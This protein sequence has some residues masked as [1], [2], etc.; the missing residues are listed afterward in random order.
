M[1]HPR[2]PRCGSDHDIDPTHSRRKSYQIDSD[3]YPKN[4]SE[5]EV[6]CMIVL[7]S[8]NA[9]K[10]AH[11]QRFIQTV[12]AHYTQQGRHDLPWR[13]TRDP[14]RIAVSEIM[15]QQT[16][17]SRVVQKYEQFLTA[18]PTVDALANAP[19]IDVLRIW[20]GLG[21]NRRAKFLHQM[22]QEIVSLGTFPDTYED[23][24]KLP[25]IGPYTAGAIYAFAYNQ[26]IPVIETNIRTVYLHH[27]FPNK[28][29]VSDGALLPII[30][31]TLDND[32]PRTWY[33][34]LMD[35]GSYLKQSGN[36]VHRASKHYTKQSV[37]KG[38]KRQLRG[39]LLR[40]LLHKSMTAPALQKV[41]QIKRELLSVVLQDMVQ[42]GLISKTKST[43]GI[44][45][46]E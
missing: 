29:E 10:T 28:A 31:R 9:P 16:Q 25:G 30:E 17:V 38:S 7:T 2:T 45:Q 36:T 26:P 21:Y 33:W 19:L 35:Y 1:V 37:F 12:T 6:F 41:L 23:L 3:Q 4:L 40:A 22:A 27:F 18:F 44:A 42:E 13:Q 24:R 8:M 11:E 34:A 20:S 5:R 32:N 46:H 15:L 39:A 14:Y 43:Y